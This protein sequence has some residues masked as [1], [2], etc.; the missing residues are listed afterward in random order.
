MY[1]YFNNVVL[2][3]GANL[4]GTNVKVFWDATK[5]T[6]HEGYTFRYG[7]TFTT[8]TIERLYPWL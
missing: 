6:L 2:I 3:D 8:Y 5:Y 7:V 1:V 4:D